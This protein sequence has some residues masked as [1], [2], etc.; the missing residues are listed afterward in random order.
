MR[1]RWIVTRNRRV[2]TQRAVALA[3]RRDV[4]IIIR[5]VREEAV[6]SFLEAPSR[7]QPILN[8]PLTRDV[9]GSY[10]RE[11]ALLRAGCFPGSW[12][13]PTSPTHVEMH[14]VTAGQ[15][16]F[17]I[18]SLTREIRIYIFFLILSLYFL[19]FFYFCFLFSRERIAC[20]FFSD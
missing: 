10:T 3:S 2:I 4:L 6:N 19:F 13:A 7:V 14:A 5:G 8:M 15:T 12:I 18:S 20:W 17:S 16:N 1:T 9:N 11:P